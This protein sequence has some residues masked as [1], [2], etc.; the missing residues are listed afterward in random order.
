MPTANPRVHVVLEK[1]LFKK[2]A[3]LAKRNN[4]T[5]SAIARDLIA[6]A[7]EISEDIALSNWI[8]QNGRLSYNRKN[9]VPLEKVSW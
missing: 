7:I 3:Q 1:P 9:L 2:V 6:E 5:L 4:L 8:E